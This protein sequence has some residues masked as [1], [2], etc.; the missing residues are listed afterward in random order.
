MDV[1]GRMLAS[2]LR[3]E[4]RRRSPWRQLVARL[5]AAVSALI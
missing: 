2:A 3:A 4:S 1:H 5:L